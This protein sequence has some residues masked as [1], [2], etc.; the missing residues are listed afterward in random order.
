MNRTSPAQHLPSPLSVTGLAA[1]LTTYDKPGITVTSHR[2]TVGDRTFVVRELTRLRTTRGPHDRL[3]V[4]AIAVTG[5]IVA[6]TALLLGL[7]G[8]L[9]RLSVGGYLC[10]GVAALVPVLIALAGRRW[11]PPAHE[12]WGSYR[13]TDQLLFSSDE[14]RQFGQVTRALLRARE[15]ARLGGWDE[16]VATADPW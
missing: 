11:R 9:Q 8:G 4:Q 3:T 5:G 7:T 15:A 16:P 12:L 1:P 2:F 6:G 14:E 10:L 13:G